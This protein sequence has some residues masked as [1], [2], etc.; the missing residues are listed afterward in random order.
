MELRVRSS[1]D[2]LTEDQIENVADTLLNRYQEQKGLIEGPPIPIEFI[3][4]DF[5]GYTVIWGNLQETDTFAYIDPNEK[6]ICF[7]LKKPDYFDRIGPEYTMAHEIGHPELNHFEEIS[8]QLDLGLENQ[9]TRFLHRNPVK[10]GYSRHEFQAEY[11]A[12]CLLMP[13][14]LILPFSKKYNLLEW[15]SLYAIADQ[16]NVSIT[17]LTNRLRNLKLIYITDKKIYKNKQEAAGMRRL[18]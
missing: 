9:P 5:L 18:L 8:K 16:L 4:E 11:F 14:W 1:V 15:N 6:K 10:N 12:S 3:V 17:A 13:R 7:N 2:Y